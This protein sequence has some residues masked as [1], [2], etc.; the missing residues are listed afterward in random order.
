[1]IFPLSVLASLWKN[2]S[3]RKVEQ[4]PYSSEYQ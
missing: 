2:I 1:V 3:P 4:N